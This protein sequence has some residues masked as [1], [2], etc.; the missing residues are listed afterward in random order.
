MVSL[1]NLVIS[2]LKFYKDNH[3]HLQTFNHHF[4]TEL[5]KSDSKLPTAIDKEA[6]KNV[7]LNEACNF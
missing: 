5:H 4:T 1:P 7:F 6:P 3:S 2:F